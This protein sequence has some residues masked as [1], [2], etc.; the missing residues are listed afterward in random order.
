MIPFSYST[1]LSTTGE[2]SIQKNTELECVPDFSWNKVHNCCRGNHYHEING[3]KKFLSYKNKFNI[4]FCYQESSW[5]HL[6]VH[7][8][9]LCNNSV[10]CSGNDL[11][12]ILI[13]WSSMKTFSY[14]ILGDFPHTL[15]GMAVD[16]KQY[17]ET[18]VFPTLHKDHKTPYIHGI[19]RSLNIKIPSSRKGSLLFNTVDLFRV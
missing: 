6:F 11:V 4:S 7:K 8:H 13:Q 19:D 10:F 9:F 1:I 17:Q 14:I 18:G 16:Q 5:Y 12:H 2:W 3:T 15:R